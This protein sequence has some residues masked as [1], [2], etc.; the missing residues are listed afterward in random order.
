MKFRMII[1]IDETLKYFDVFT[2][3]SKILIE[4]RVISEFFFSIYSPNFANMQER[5]IKKVR[6]RLSDKKNF[7]LEFF[8]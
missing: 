1:E 5:I 8:I 3:R 2:P 6:Q 4:D 7:I